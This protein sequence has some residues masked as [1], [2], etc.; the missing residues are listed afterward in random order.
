MSDRSSSSASSGARATRRGLGLGSLARP[1][2]RVASQKR[3]AR[4]RVASRRGATRC[5]VGSAAPSRRSPRSCAPVSRLRNSWL[6]LLTASPSSASRFFWRSWSARPCAMRA[7]AVSATP[8]SSVRREGTMP[9]SAP[10]G[11]S[12]KAAMLRASRRTGRTIATCSTT[13][14]TPAAAAATIREDSSSRRAKSTIA[15]RSGAS[16]IS[17]STR[18]KPSRPCPTTRM[19]AS[20]GAKIV[21]QPPR[22]ASQIEGSRR[23]TMSATRSGTGSRESRRWVVSPRTAITRAPAPTSRWRARSSGTG[24]PWLASSTM[25]ATC[26]AAIRSESSDRR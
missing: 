6:I 26:A 19:G 12:A 16:S 5:T 13:K 25:A 21:R 22:I 3:I 9:R 8:I 7:S 15:R 17:T 20:A 10:S 1:Y 2:A 18:S 14:T 11:S 23:S 4:S 24:W